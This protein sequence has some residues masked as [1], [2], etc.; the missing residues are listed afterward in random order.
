MSIEILTVT[1]CLEFVKEA[2]VK[3]TDGESLEN[4]LSAENAGASESVES[5]SCLCGFSVKSEISSLAGDASVNNNFNLLSE[6]SISP[7]PLFTCHHSTVKMPAFTVHSLCLKCFKC[8]SSQ[9]NIECLC[10]KKLLQCGVCTNL[11]KL[12]VSISQGFHCEYN[13]CLELAQNGASS[14]LQN[15]VKERKKVDQFHGAISK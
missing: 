5:S 1:H 10:H 13:E 14:V 4:E 7:Y 15:C 12:C 2:I 11:N 9:T 8:L 3:N 6:F